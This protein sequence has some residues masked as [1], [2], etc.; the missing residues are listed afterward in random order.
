M[1]VASEA[2]RLDYNELFEQSRAAQAEVLQSLE[3]LSAVQ[4]EHM[5]LSA[6]LM[7]RGDY[8]FQRIT[9]PLGRDILIRTPE[10]FL[11]LPAED[12][13]TVSAVWAS[14]GRL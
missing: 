1:R 4:S 11:L 7:S 8:L 2:T 5:Q 12:P 10:G 14:G 9:I 6:L 3:R 13:A